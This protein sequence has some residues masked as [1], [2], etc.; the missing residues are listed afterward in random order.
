MEPVIT[1]LLDYSNRHYTTL[2]RDW[3]VG[4][5]HTALMVPVWPT[6]APPL[7]PTGCATQLIKTCTHNSICAKL[8]ML[9]YTY[10]CTYVSTHIFAREFD[11]VNRFYNL[12]YCYQIAD[13]F[14]WKFCDF[15]RIWFSAYR[16]CSA[17]RPLLW[18]LVNALQLLV[19]RAATCSPQT[20]A[21]NIELNQ[22][23]YLG[24]KTA[25]QLIIYCIYKYIA[26]QLFTYGTVCKQIYCF[27]FIMILSFGSKELRF[28]NVM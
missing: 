11:A 14:V 22:L 18:F 1:P 20:V 26:E 12:L 7:Q 15:W 24:S 16:W 2:G 5:F 25:V 27:P 23:K 4:W 21:G 28:V 8:C 17:L 19:E 9:V 3:G 6:A 10:I 13:S